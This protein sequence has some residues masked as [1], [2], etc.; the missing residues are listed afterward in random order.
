VKKI[1]VAAHDVAV[2]EFDL[3]FYQGERV[4]KTKDQRI[5]ARRKLGIVPQRLCEFS[6]FENVAELFGSPE[7]D[8]NIGLNA[9]VASLFHTDSRTFESEKAGRPLAE[10]SE[11]GV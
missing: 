10:F 1:V 7:G 5:C 2:Q 6:H 11:S 8:T 4:H 9:K 3:A